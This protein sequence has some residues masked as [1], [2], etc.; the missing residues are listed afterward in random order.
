MTQNTADVNHTGLKKTKHQQ[1][2]NP[3]EQK[4]N[5]LFTELIVTGLFERRRQSD[6][7]AGVMMLRLRK[8]GTVE[9]E[10]K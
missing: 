6:A 8:H 1:R 4:M 9:R 3:W 5:S 10:N 2:Q 7:D